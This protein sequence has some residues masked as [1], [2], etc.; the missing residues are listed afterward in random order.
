MRAVYRPRLSGHRVAHCGAPEAGVP[1]CGRCLPPEPGGTRDARAAEAVLPDQP[2]GVGAGGVGAEP[3]ELLA[4]GDAERLTDPIAAYREAGVIG[5][6]ASDARVGLSHSQPR[7]RRMEP[8][9]TTMATSKHVFTLHGVDA[10]DRVVL[11]RSQ[12]EAC[13]VSH[14]WGRV[15]QRLGHGAPR[16]ACFVRTRR[17]IQPAQ[18]PCAAG[19]PTHGDPRAAVHRPRRLHRASA[20]RREARK[21]REAT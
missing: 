13:G 6:A 10:E 16:E 1:P 3:A 21:R 9:R 8:K 14:H 20:R 4:E 19:A 7:S 5:A 2:G 15:P 11:R 12:V 18:I 17:R